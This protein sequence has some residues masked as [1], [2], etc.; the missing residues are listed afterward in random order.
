M[1][2]ATGREPRGEQSIFNSPLEQVGVGRCE[3]FHHLESRPDLF[4]RRRNIEHPNTEHAKWSAD[5]FDKL[6]STGVKVPNFRTV[7]GEDSQGKAE[8]I[9]ADRVF[10]DPLDSLV[11]AKADLPQEAVD[12][13]F[14]G[15]LTYLRKGQLAE[16]PVLWDLALRQ[17]MYG[18][19][20][21]EASDDIYLVDIDPTFRKVDG[22]LLVRVQDMMLA[23]HTLT[24]IEEESWLLMRELII[25]NDTGKVS[26]EQMSE[27]R[28]WL[29]NN[30]PPRPSSPDISKL[31][32]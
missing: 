18:H 4:I 2:E 6:R 31:T 29:E 15:L 30:L 28:V 32:R 11:A 20:L 27:T 3:T 14:K 12:R 8:F 1:S 10:G 13:T 24:P 25:A 26:E 23:V 21:G 19:T 22:E 9:I 16:E 7:V 17:F 5:Q